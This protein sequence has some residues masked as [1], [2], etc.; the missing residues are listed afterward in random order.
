MR[1]FCSNARLESLSLAFSSSARC[2]V[3]KTSSVGTV[4][5]LSP[6]PASGYGKHS[7]PQQHSFP[8]MVSSPSNHEN[9]DME[10]DIVLEQGSASTPAH[11]RNKP[12]IPP[13]SITA[14]ETTSLQVQL[15]GISASNKQ[16]SPTKTRSMASDAGG[17]ESQIGLTS[18]EDAT[19]RSV[20]QRIIHDTPAPGRKSSF[21]THVPTRRSKR[22][23]SIVI[24]IPPWTGPKRRMIP[25]EG[26]LVKSFK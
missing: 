15:D 21:G 1:L 2:I 12:A 4:P 22:K 6:R 23:T 5:H 26:N 7:L 13:A 16:Q 10:V 25:L 17:D 18:H 19:A 20:S 24:E 3:P 14:V 9:M 11:R 8:A